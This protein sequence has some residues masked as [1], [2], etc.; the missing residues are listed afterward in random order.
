M[1]DVFRTG[2]LKSFHLDR[3]Q[4]DRGDL[5]TVLLMLPDRVLTKACHNYG[6]WALLVTVLLDQVGVHRARFPRLYVEIEEQR[7]DG[8]DYDRYESPDSLLH[9]NTPCPAYFQA[10]RN[11]YSAILECWQPRAG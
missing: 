7:D 10:I 5:H 8:E 6:A 9:R 4:P 2:E 1:N 11:R 3:R